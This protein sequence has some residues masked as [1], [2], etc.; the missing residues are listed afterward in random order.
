MQKDLLTNIDEQP[1]MNKIF[2]GKKGIVES[3]VSASYPLRMKVSEMTGI[4]ISV[5]KNS[6]NIK[7]PFSFYDLK[8]NL[9]VGYEISFE[10]YRGKKLLIVNV[11][12]K[13]GYTP[14]YTSLE[15]LYKSESDLEILGFP[16][17]E[18][19]NQE[20][21]EDKDI[22]DFCE[23]NF[24]VSFPL[25]QKSMVT[26]KDKNPVFDW[27]T[28]KTKNGWNDLEPGWN[29]YKY[30]VNEEGNLMVVASSSVEPAAMSDQL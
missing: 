11:A 27:L 18:F 30:L 14:Q 25:F 12:S 16:S 28:D 7:A 29:F 26:G 21:G 9:N 5:F 4:G 3:L 22:A 1:F 17:N 15:N 23:M 2:K 24:G 20:P 13:C 19:G 6:E 10:R 8:M